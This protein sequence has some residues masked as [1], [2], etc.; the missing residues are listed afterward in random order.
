MARRKKRDT[1]RWVILARPEQR[2]GPG[3]VFIARDGSKTGSRS[4]AAKFFSA[5]TAREWAEEKGITLDGARTYV[6]QMEFTEWDLR[7]E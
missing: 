5:D 6:E 2:G 4:D 3:N 1:T 7:D